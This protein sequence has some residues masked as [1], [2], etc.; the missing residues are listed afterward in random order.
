VGPGKPARTPKRKRRGVKERDWGQP[1]GG[2]QKH[3]PGGCG[4]PKIQPAKENRP[5]TGGEL[6]T[7]MSEFTWEDTGQGT[8]LK[9]KLGWGG[10]SVQ[11]TGKLVKYTEK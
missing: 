6:N 5:A 9:K 4:A 2:N 10:G 7:T 8:Q 3:Y 1:S 11:S